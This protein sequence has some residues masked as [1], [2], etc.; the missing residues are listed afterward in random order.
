MLTLLG[1]AQFMLILDITV[2]TIA[3][4]DIGA[5]LHLS[6]ASLTW[7]IT[8]YTVLFGGLMLLGGRAADL[9]GARRIVLIGLIMFVVASL[10]S[11][12]ALNAPMLIGGRAG[13]GVGAALLS[14]AAL[15]IVTTTFHGPERNKALGVWAALGGTGS[16][17][18]V[19][20]GGVLTAGPGWEWIFYINVPVGLAVLAL[21]PAVLPVALRQD[22]ARRVDVAGALLVTAATGAT[23]YGLINAGD[24]GWAAPSTLW[25]LAVA[26]L[27]Y[28]GFALA[29]RTVRAPLMDLRILARRPVLTA[30]FLILIATGLLVGS[31]FLGSFYLQQVRGYSALTTGLLFLP[32]AVGT[33]IGAHS[34]SR[35]VGHLGPRAVATAALVLAALGAATPALW[36]GPTALVTGIS[37]AAA[38]LGATFVSATTTGLARVA[39]HEAGVTSGIINTFHELGAATGVAVISTTAAV[40]LATAGA[41]TVGFSNAFTVTALTAAAAAVVALLLVPPGKPPAGVVPHA[42]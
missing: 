21:L 29:Q 2:V 35:A 5:D 39:H 33:V 36:S 15:S 37:V 18:G 16:A 23:I 13:Q 34:A 8:A 4:P 24:H 20:L 19:L 10:V 3:L 14:P 30:A 38:G 12:L 22:R 42:H 6:R 7:V 9:F 31:F 28:L 17:V 1:I 40:S 27:L 25:P 41:T 32:P 11:G 26:V